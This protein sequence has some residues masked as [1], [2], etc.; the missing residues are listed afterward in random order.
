MS[1][2]GNIRLFVERDYL[3]MSALAETLITDSIQE[4]LSDQEHVTLMPSAGGTPERL[5]RNLRE[6][7]KTTIDW[8]RIVVF[9]MDEYL[10]LPPND[11]HSLANFLL[12]EFII[13]LNIKR[14]CLFNDRT[15]NL[16]HDLREYERIIEQTNGIDIMILGIGQNGHL[17]FNE[18]GSTFDSTTRIVDLSE[19]TITANSRFF[20]EDASLVP[21][22]GITIGLRSVLNAKQNFL[23]ASGA[24]KRTAIS[25]ALNGPV[26]TQVPASILRLHA[27]AR[28]IVDEEAAAN[29]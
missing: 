6:R 12:T 15:G 27:N 21:R 26:T 8:S 5:Y 16:R 10:D 29:G 28:A 7:Q 23:L 3:A 13:P 11:P 22:K 9:Q 20:D 2:A 4:K 18:P 1:T 17:G 24:M 19:S 14:Y 25:S